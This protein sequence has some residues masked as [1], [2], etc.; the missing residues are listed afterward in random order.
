[1][2]HLLNFYKPWAVPG[3]REKHSPNIKTHSQLEEDLM[4]MWYEP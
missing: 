4:F 3:A 1:M 2:G